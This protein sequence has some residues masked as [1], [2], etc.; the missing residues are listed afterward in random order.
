MQ[1]PIRLR[2]NLSGEDLAYR[3][4]G[5]HE[6]TVSRTFFNVLDALYMRRNP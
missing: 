1:T 6:T 4:G 3:F 5:V 2:L